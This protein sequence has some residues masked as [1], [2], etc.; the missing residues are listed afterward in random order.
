MSW[1][2]V[3]ERAGL[4]LVCG[5]LSLTP[6]PFVM[7]RGKP[8]SPA[9]L[10]RIWKQDGWIRRLSGLMLEPSTAQ[11][12]VAKLIASLLDTPASRLASRD[13]SEPI[14]THGICGH[15]LPA[16]PVKS[17]PNG[18]FSRTSPTIYRWGF[19]LSERV[20]R[21]NPL[22]RQGSRKYGKH[23][24]CS[25][26]PRYK[27]GVTVYSSNVTPSHDGVWYKFLVFCYRKETP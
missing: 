21:A 25:T 18:A 2:Y 3:P 5:S 4:S 10:S 14:K 15:T 19:V 24:L 8:M 23:K 7:L 22:R 12:G 20:L 6:M 9:S 17:N 1:L 11:A 13:A 26:R 27:N 16:S